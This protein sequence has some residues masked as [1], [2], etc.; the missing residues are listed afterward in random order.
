M[1]VVIA[2]DMEGAAGIDRFEQ[3]FPY[4]PEAFTAGC[5][6]LITDINACIRGLR[7]GG[8]TEIKVIEGHA[9]GRF[10]A[11]ESSDLD[12]RPEVLRG[13]PSIEALTSWAQAVA[14]LGYHAMNGT[15]DGFLSHTVTGSTAL[16]L[17]GEPVGEMV[18]TAASAGV[19]GIPVILVTGDHATAR[20]ARAFLPWTV[21][22]EVKRATSVAAV[23]LRPR[24]HASPAIEDG[25]RQAMARVAECPP[26]RLSE[27]IETE[28]HFRSPELADAAMILPFARRVGDRAVG[29]TAP[30]V[31]EAMRFF[32]AA[33]AVIMPVRERSLWERLGT[34][35]DVQRIR[36]EWML[37]LL[38]DWLEG[39]SPFIA[40][41]RA[42]GP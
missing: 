29:F 40:S 31:Q 22:V 21:R 30:T 42:V 35:P 17:A 1:R 7:H 11:F 39:R 5:R 25:A 27:P 16:H 18:M 4:Y 12:G 10:R 23:T 19:Q 13:R 6:E 14:L 33:C 37:D 9:W 8:A 15:K 34:L 3:T 32:G 36:A 2:T 41:P 24:D 26:L 28:A 38:R 20:E